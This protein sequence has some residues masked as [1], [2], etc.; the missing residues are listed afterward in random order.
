MASAANPV[1]FGQLIERNRDSPRARILDGLRFYDGESNAKQLRRYGD[2][3]SGI[4]HFGE[5]EKQGLIE[6]VG[7]EYVGRGGTATTYQLTDRGQE[8][9]DE[10]ADSPVEATQLLERVE[11]QEQEIEELQSELDRLGELYNEVV[12]YVEEIDERSVDG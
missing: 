6:S 1:T 12:E 11:R 9:A 3:P 2:I 10:L 8:V 7:E 5:L 4:Y